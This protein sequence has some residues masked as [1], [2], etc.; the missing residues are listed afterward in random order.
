[1]VSTF[2]K[3]GAK[4]R[5]PS[6][7]C[8]LQIDPLAF[9][10]ERSP[11]SISSIMNHNY[12]EAR[13]SRNHFHDPPTITTRVL[14]T[15]NSYSP[16]LLE[17]WKTFHNSAGRSSKQKKGP[18]RRVFSLANI[19]TAIWIITIYWG[20]RRLFSNSIEACDWRHWESW[21]CTS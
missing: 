2:P 7:H 6:P 5:N 3:S 18:L 19:L 13:S 17:R 4:Q 16:A 12:G 1:M 9:Q 14:G 15:I 10:N 11:N 8:N 21:V 20:E